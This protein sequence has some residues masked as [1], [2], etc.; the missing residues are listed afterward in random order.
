MLTSVNTNFPIPAASIS[1]KRI[2]TAD[3]L[4]I[5]RICTVDT[6]TTSEFIYALQMR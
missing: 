2:Y 1:S 6:L 5:E 3:T 4:T